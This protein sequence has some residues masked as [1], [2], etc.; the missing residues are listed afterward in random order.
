MA[1]TEMKIRKATPKTQPYK[2]G[3]G[4]GLWLKVMPSGSKIWHF[5]FTING[6]ESI[7][8]IGSYPAIGLKE[9]RDKSHELRKLV[10]EGVNPVAKKKEMKRLA[11]FNSDN[12]FIA[13]ATE[14]YNTN[15]NNWTPDH[16][17]KLW[18]RLELHILPTLGSRLIAEISTLELL[19]VLRKPEKDGKTETTHRILQ[20]C[21]QIF[22]FGVLMQKLK[23]NPAN[24][25]DG[26]LKVHKTVS[27]PTI[28][29]NQLPEFI[30]KLEQSP[31]SLLNRLAIKMLLL[32]F[33]RQGELR[34][35]KWSDVD[36][37]AAEWRIR[38][39]TTK[40]RT[41]HHVPLSKQALDVLRE[42]HKLSGDSEYIFPS[43][44][45]RR[46]PFMS[47]NTI[48]KVIHQMGYK[49][50]LVG[51]GF[52]SLASTILNEQGFRADVIERQLAHMP[53][54]RIRAAYN[55]AEYLMERRDMMN[56]W[57]KFLMGVGL[58]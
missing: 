31:T 4:G 29:H 36:F 33:V 41:L 40:M 15:K 54:D 53:R 26:V 27:Y 18:R 8:S 57:A 44:Q 48:N 37:K 21:R 34:R 32:T 42:I 25:L 58:K 1:L 5:R 14:W 10:S 16:A 24:D 43:Q 28:G 23:Y 20:T 3:D 39:E 19:D 45:H 6:K 7:T 17:Q 50:V 35:A 11:R 38:P 46:N 47:E 56:W 9:A 52:R 49:G 13:V 30:E 22:R 2:I 55:R 12:S 51:H